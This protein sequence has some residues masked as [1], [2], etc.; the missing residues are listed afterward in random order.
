MA[1]YHGVT[2][3]ELRSGCGILGLVGSTVA[4]PESRWQ[5]VFAVTFGIFSAEDL[6]QF[7]RV[8]LEEIDRLVPSKI[9][10]FNGDGPT[11]GEPPLYQPGPF[12][13]SL[14]ALVAPRPVLAYMMNVVGCLKGDGSTEA[15]LG[16]RRTLSE[17]EPSHE[18]CY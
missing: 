17:Q 9:S 1:F 7:A 6:D 10:W 14:A 8:V 15:A 16:C 13:G 2:A 4:V 18:H 12:P 5:D 11:S 3:R